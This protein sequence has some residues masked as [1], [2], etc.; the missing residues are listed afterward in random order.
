MSCVV[1]VSV[2]VRQAWER[3]ISAR[4]GCL[5]MRLQWRHLQHHKPKDPQ[6]ALA[7]DDIDVEEGIIRIQI[8]SQPFHPLRE[9]NLASEVEAEEAEPTKIGW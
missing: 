9:A 8:L 5:C 2:C 4:M 6:E 3:R 1:I 7:T